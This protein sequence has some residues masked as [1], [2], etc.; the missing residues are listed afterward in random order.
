MKQKVIRFFYW[1][2]LALALVVSLLLGFSPFKY[3]AQTESYALETE[4]VIQKP[5][6]EV[7][8]YLGNSGNAAFWSVFV[9]HITP[10]NPQT[11]QDGTEGSKRR[12]FRNKNE[13]GIFWDETVLENIT[14][15]TRTL[16]IYNLNGFPIT[17]D[18]LITKQEYQN[19]G[20]EGTLLLFGLYKSSSEL[21]AIDWIKIKLAG[22]VVASI[23]KDNLKG[24]KHQ[25]EHK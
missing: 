19:L 23:F 20:D 1:M 13:K 14:D 21:N 5:V 6:K 2:C 18:N 4:I 10:L 3:N 24:I 22:Y 15:R 17:T 16:N 12:C 9:D 11:H 8:S 7:F 25:L